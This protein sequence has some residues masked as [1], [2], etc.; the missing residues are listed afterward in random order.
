[1]IRS[2]VIIFLGIEMAA[3]EEKMGKTIFDLVRQTID[4]Q[5]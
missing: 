5:N 4:E 2:K 3:K 1:M